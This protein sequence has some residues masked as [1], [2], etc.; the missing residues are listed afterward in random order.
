VTVSVVS[1]WRHL[2]PDSEEYLRGRFD[3]YDT[4]SESF[5]PGLAHEG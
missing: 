2:L 5:S 3:S 4:A 1:T